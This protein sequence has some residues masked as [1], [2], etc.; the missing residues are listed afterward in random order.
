MAIYGIDINP[1]KPWEFI[2]YGDDEY[3]RMYDKRHIPSGPAKIFRRPS[4]SINI[5]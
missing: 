2:I 4:V 3:I 5:L 1:L